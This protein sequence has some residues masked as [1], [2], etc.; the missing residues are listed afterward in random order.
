M[1]AF[2]G[3]TD[4]AAIIVLIVAIVR[5]D[6]CLAMTYII[7]CLFEVFSLIIVLGYYLQ[8]DMGKNAPSPPGE[9]AE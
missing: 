5:Y 7:L 8:T 1:G 6:F 4:L 9:E 2:S 3:F